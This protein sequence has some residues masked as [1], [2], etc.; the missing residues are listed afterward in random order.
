MHASKVDTSYSHIDYSNSLLV[1][2]CCTN[3]CNL[4]T[5]QG[6]FMGKTNG[7]FI[8]N[9]QTVGCGW[10]TPPTLELSNHPPHPVFHDSAPV[11]SCHRPKQRCSTSSRKRSIPTARGSTSFWCEPRPGPAIGSHQWGQETVGW[12][13]FPE[14]WEKIKIINNRDDGLKGNWPECECCNGDLMLVWYV[15]YDQTFAYIWTLCC[16]DSGKYARIRY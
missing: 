2:T 15:S 11:P 6:W 8:Q 4:P 13:F 16:V 9:K 12:F 10:K 5:Y 7:S 3:M 1:H 14:E